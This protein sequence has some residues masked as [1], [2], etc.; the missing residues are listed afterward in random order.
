M[1]RHQNAVVVI[2]VKHAVSQV[3]HMVALSS[4]THFPYA[5]M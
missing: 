5:L 1:L 3:A 2:Q 4:E